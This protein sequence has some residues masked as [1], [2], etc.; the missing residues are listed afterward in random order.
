MEQVDASWVPGDASVAA[1]DM[2]VVLDSHLE[3]GQWW[4]Q[5]QEELVAEEF[6]SVAVHL[7][8]S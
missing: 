2:P 7:T 6:V 4:A 5:E 1:M 8:L 3:A